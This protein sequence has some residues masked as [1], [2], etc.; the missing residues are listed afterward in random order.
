MIHY[1]DM[2]RRHA[3]EGGFPANRITEIETVI[4]P[5]TG[6]RGTRERGARC[7]PYLRRRAADSERALV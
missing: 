7:A 6:E 5:T 3:E 1:Q 2:I 4:A